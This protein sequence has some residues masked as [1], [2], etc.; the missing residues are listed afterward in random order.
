MMPP[1]GMSVTTGAAGTNPAKIV[2]DEVPVR[3]F[4]VVAL[5]DKE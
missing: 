2:E 4:A 1:V 3:L 5:A